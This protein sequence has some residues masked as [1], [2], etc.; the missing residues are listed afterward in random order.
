MASID[1]FLSKRVEYLK[2][3]LLLR[4]KRAEVFKELCSG[5]VFTKWKLARDSGTTIYGINKALEPLVIAGLVTVKSEKITS[6]LSRHEVKVNDGGKLVCKLL[7]PADEVVNDVLKYVS[8]DDRE[9]VEVL[10]K[11][12]HGRELIAYAIT[13]S[14][15]NRIERYNSSPINEQ[16]LK[17][18]YSTAISQLKVWFSFLFGAKVILELGKN[19]NK[20]NVG[21]YESSLINIAEDLLVKSIFYNKE[22]KPFELPEKYGIPSKRETKGSSEFEEWFK[23]L[24]VI[25]YEELNKIARNELNKFL[26][27]EVEKDVNHDIENVCW[28]TSLKLSLEG[29]D[30]N[31][32]LKIKDKLGKDIE[33]TVFSIFMDK[34]HKEL[35]KALE[36]VIDF[37]K[38]Y[39]T[40]TTMGKSFNLNS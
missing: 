36:Q 18:I 22:I 26:S 21:E 7:G 1:E 31:K 35:S 19:E 3:S 9:F 23:R 24:Y 39:E 13:G 5:G 10:A 32:S 14:L 29:M 28:W 4:G 6:K 8:N 17:S 30:L 33:A 20:V 27:R 25:T 16:E 37:V 2:E 12:Q 15:V 11:G 40:N 34:C 38:Q